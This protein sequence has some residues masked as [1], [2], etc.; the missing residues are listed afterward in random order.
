MKKR[1]DG[2][3]CST[4][5]IDGKKHFVYGE[6]PKEVEVN[7][8]QFL[9]NYSKI[10]EKKT[11]GGTFK[12]VAEE[13]WEEHKPTLAYSSLRYYQAPFNNVVENFGENLIKEILPIRVDMYLK[14]LAAKG[15]SHKSVFARLMVLR[16]IFDY[17]VLH[18][19][20]QYNPA[21]SVK[22]PKNLSKKERE[23]PDEDIVAKIKNSIG[24]TFYLFA[25]TALY[26]GCRRGELLAL[27]SDDIDLKNK[28]ININ[29]SVYHVHN[30][31]FVKEPKTKNGIRTIPLL[32]PLESILKLLNIKGY[33]FNLN[34]EM[35]TDKQARTLW[36]KYCSETGI[37]ITPHQLRHAYATRLYELDIDE[38]SA[39]DLLGHADVQ[40]TKNIYTHIR[41]TKRK[42]TAE[43]L[44]AF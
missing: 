39:Q 6:S 38:K 2:R 35:L 21:L 24:N 20:I 27:T 14:S 18:G 17:S 43:Q 9:L 11:N 23:A 25:L 13:W 41:D 8:K 32:E 7:K 30:K 42:I 26:T 1:K 40:T 44:K 5:T 33:L 28:T 37:D 15:Y 12:E 34:G 3:Y 19:H 36:D 16:Q 29:K 4:V 10:Q 31:P 22:V